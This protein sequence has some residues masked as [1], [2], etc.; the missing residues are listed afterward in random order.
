MKKII[1]ILILNVLAFL[2][3]G[4]LSPSEYRVKSLTQEKVLE[5]LRSPSTAKFIDENIDV[6][7]VDNGNRAYVSGE[8]DAQNAFGTTVRSKY[9]SVVVKENGSWVVGTVQIVAR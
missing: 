5:Q 3:L 1:L 9:Y 6:K 2:I 8:V 4:C 7:I